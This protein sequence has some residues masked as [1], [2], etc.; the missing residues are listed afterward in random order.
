[1]NRIAVSLMCQG[2]TTDWHLQLGS[3]PMSPPPYQRARPKL[4]PVKPTY[5]PPALSRRSHKS[6][7]TDLRNA[8]THCDRCIPA[9][10]LTTRPH[11]RIATPNP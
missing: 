7:Q 11:T 3:L 9:T 8:G 6:Y 1:V 2:S 5:R 10:A 4:W